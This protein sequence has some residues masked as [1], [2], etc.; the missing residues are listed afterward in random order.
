MFLTSLYH[1]T[2]DSNFH[3]NS[4]TTNQRLRIYVAVLADVS[5]D[6]SDENLG[7]RALKRNLKPLRTPLHFN[8]PVE[9]RSSVMLYVPGET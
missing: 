3:L 4:L 7:G 6:D 9:S 8:I 2:F 1:H 5:D